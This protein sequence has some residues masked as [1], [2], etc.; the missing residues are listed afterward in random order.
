MVK[1]LDAI[2]D[3]RDTDESHT[4][5]VRWLLVEVCRAYARHRHAAPALRCLARVGESGNLL[6]QVTRARVELAAAMAKVA[7]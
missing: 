5:R 2:R 4:Q 7:R 1:R 6:A 3:P